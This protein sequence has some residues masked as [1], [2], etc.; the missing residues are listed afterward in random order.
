[1]ESLGESIDVTFQN[2]KRQSYSSYSNDV[3]VDDVPDVS[4]LIGG[5]RVLAR[6]PKSTSF[7]PGFVNGT[8]EGLPLNDTFLVNY[9]SGDSMARNIMEIRLATKPSSCSKYIW[10]TFVTYTILYNHCKYYN[11]LS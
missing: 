9:D 4:E 6:R 5:S 1:M 3:I 8:I 2:G 7:E 11:Y 10:G